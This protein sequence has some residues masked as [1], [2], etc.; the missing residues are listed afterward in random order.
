MKYEAPVIIET[1]ESAED[2]K[3][4]L[5]LNICGGGCIK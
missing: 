4:A 2:N 3:S 5:D 1:T